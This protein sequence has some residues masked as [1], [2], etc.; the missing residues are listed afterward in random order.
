MLTEDLPLIEDQCRMVVLMVILRAVEDYQLCIEYGYIK[1]AK[2]VNSKVYS[3]FKSNTGRLGLGLSE[4]SD[5]QSLI[6]FFHKGGLETS[7]DL[8][9]LDVEPDCIKRA[10]K[11]PYGS[12]SGAF[13]GTTEANFSKCGT[14]EY[15]AELNEI[16]FY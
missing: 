4:P 10:I 5:I 8:A 12:I 14:F 6:Y 1:D 9:R 13:F 2:V 3:M 7:L 15:I 11:L 16:D